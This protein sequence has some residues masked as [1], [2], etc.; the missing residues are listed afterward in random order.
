MRTRQCLTVGCFIALLLLINQPSSLANNPDKDKNTKQSSYF[1]SFKNW[2]ASVTGAKDITDEAKPCVDKSRVRPGAFC[3]QNYE[4]VCG[5]DNKTYTNP[6]IANKNGV[7]S[8]TAGICKTQ[9]TCVD[10]QK[11]NESAFCNKA[12]NPVCGCDGRT[13]TN[14]CE[15]KK[16][17][18]IFYSFGSCDNSA[19]AACIDKSKADPNLWCSTKYDPVCGCDGVTYL[20]PCEAERNGVISYERGACNK[21]IACID[22]SKVNPNRICTQEYMPVCGCDGKTYPNA[23]TAQGQGVV[24]FQFGACR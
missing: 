23:C 17:G 2:L 22:K 6:C 21:N 14:P 16:N 8:Y 20:N 10:P 24:S 1:Q 3:T 19:S 15:A 4:P 9:N 5:C 7:T 12:Y 18:V 11:V 13:Y